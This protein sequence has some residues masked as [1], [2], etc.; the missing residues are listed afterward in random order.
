MTE[1][2]KKDDAID[3]LIS[4]IFKSTEKVSNF[5][6]ILMD[7]VTVEASKT[8]SK[9]LRFQ[10]KSLVSANFTESQALHIVGVMARKLFL[11]TE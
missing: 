5:E 1:E 2:P 7:P 3:R 11:G 4:D 9:L 10:Y 6:K 8:I